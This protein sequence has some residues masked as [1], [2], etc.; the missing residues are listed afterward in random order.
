MSSRL[1]RARIL[2]F[3][4]L[5]SRLPSACAHDRTR[6]RFLVRRYSMDRSKAELLSA[7]IC[8][9][10]VIP[11]SDAGEACYRPRF[12]EAEVLRCACASGRHSG[13]R[14]GPGAPAQKALVR[15]RQGAVR[16]AEGG[17][18]L[19]VAPHAPR[20]HLQQSAHQGR[21]IGRHVPREE[22]PCRRSRAPYG[23]DARSPQYDALE[24]IDLEALSREAPLIF[25]QIQSDY[26]L[27]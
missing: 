1:L 23:H 27:G 10:E 4:Y 17:P 18:R 22:L 7:G 5:C 16:R 9:G 13:V 2:D 14:R 11:P 20:R 15:L 12:R 25:E 26:G 19:P 3:L 24:I 8:V 21:C 6:R